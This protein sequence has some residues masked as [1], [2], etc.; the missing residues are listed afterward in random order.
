MKRHFYLLLVLSFG[1]LASCKKKEGCGDPRAINYDSEVKKDNGTCI[2]EEE[3]EEEQYEVPS[4]YT[5]NA[6]DYSGQ[7][8]RLKMLDM[9]CDSV[10]AASTTKKVTYANLE[11][12]FKNSSGTLFGTDK[13]L[14]SKTYA[15]DQ[16]YFLDLLTTIDTTTNN[17]S[18]YLAGTYYVTNSGLEIDQLVQKGL[19]GAV[20]YYQATSVYL[21]NIASDDNTEAG[22]S[23]ATDMEHHFDEAFGYF[24]IPTNFSSTSATGDADF[25]ANANFWGKYCIE[26][27]SQLSN[28]DTIFNA[29]RT[30]RAAISNSDYETRDKAI[31]T[32]RTE[33]EKIAAANVVHYI[34]DVK[35]YIAL[36][37]DG[38]KF[39]AWAEGKGFAMSL[40]Y[41][42]AKKISDAD[43]TTVRNAFGDKPGD[44][45]SGSDFD[46]ALTILKN[47]YGFS[48]A[49]MTNL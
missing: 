12:I 5:F 47:T 23:T 21:E 7:T 20:L 41:N 14:Y 11:S 25:V 2:Y 32:I 17:G 45:T 33:W 49:Q 6:V 4:T 1:V 10:N 28:L 40:K 3:E 42:I 48:D 30:G 22:G 29:F 13:N 16:Q 15:S 35:E 34:N 44:V 27:N 9:L 18:G 43:L 46:A 8:A 31:A 36:G 39:H 19:M 38:K 24:G 37:D 26:R